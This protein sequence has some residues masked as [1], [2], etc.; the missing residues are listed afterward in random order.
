[1]E[2]KELLKQVREKAQEWLSETYDEETRNEVQGV[3]SMLKIPPN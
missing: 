3:C 2:N 1:M